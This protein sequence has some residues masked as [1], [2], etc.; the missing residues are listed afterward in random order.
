M[1]VVYLP[2]VF[3]Q[4][5]SPAI[6]CAKISSNDGFD[7]ICG[8]LGLPVLNFS[9]TLQASERHV[10]VSYRHRRNLLASTRDSPGFRDSQGGVEGHISKF[11]S[12]NLSLRPVCNQKWNERSC[13]FWVSNMEVLSVF[14]L[15][16]LSSLFLHFLLV[17]MTYI[18]QSSPSSLLTRS[19]MC[20]LRWEWQTCLV[21]EQI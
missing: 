16:I 15:L 19:E 9:Y 3:H 13:E 4:L 21:I 18:S 6:F 7:I 1:N 10:V 5:G 11:C 12:G 8:D 17:R 2:S 20:W 14:Q